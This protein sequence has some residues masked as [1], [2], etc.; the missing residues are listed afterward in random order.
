[1]LVENE[2][3]SFSL[4][5]NKTVLSFLQMKHTDQIKSIELGMKFI[6][7][8]NHQ[9][10]S[11]SNE[12]WTL[13]LDKEREERN[14][15]IGRYKDLLRNQ[16]DTLCLLKENH[17]EQIQLKHKF[18]INANYLPRDQIPKLNC[19][20]NCIVNKFKSKNPDGVT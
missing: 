14:N 1:M 11:W 16:Q 10:Q 5:V 3:I 12:E 18:Q 19:I 2:E 9:I 4:P 13:K 17:Q 8:G 15:E 20:L 7:M 6:N